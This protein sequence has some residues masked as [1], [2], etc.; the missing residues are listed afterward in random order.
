[1]AQALFL[2]ACLR[3]YC[4]WRW[5]CLLAY[6]Q[7]GGAADPVLAGVAPHGGVGPVPGLRGVFVL[8]NWPGMFLSLLVDAH[9]SV[10]ASC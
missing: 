6:M 2:L 3:C 10:S 1:M 4:R 9:G 5:C 8:T 7:Q